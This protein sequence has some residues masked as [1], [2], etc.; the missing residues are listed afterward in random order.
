MPSKLLFPDLDTKNTTDDEAYIYLQKYI[1]QNFIL[2]QNDISIIATYF[3]LIPQEHGH[4]FVCEITYPK[5]DLLGLKIQNT[6]LFNLFK[7]Q[8]NYHKIKPNQDVEYNFTTT[9]NQQAF[10][11]IKEN[12]SQLYDY[13]TII[14]GLSFLSSFIFGFLKL[15]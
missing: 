15:K 4:S 11:T 3:Q 10:I 14:L 12:Q 6:L 2:I 9:I 5:T 7:N 13:R 1:H 8:K